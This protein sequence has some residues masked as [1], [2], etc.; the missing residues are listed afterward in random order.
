MEI[1]HRYNRYWFNLVY[2]IVKDNGETDEIVQEVFFQIWNKAD[3]YNPKL[4]SFS[5]WIMTIARNKALDKLRRLKYKK[6]TSDIDQQQ[7]KSDFYDS[8]ILIL[9]RKIYL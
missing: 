1:Y 2:L 4:A 5:T 7:V 9:E 8:N 6:Q 3:R